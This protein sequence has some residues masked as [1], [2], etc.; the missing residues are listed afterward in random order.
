MR[1]ESLEWLKTIS[2]NSIKSVLEPMDGVERVDIELEIGQIRIAR[3]L[4]Q[5][6]DLKVPPQMFLMDRQIPQGL[7]WNGDLLYIT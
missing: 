5:F 4:N 2:I 1:S 6:Q 3:S 7:N